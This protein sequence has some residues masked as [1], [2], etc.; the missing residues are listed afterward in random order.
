MP[1]DIRH[2]VVLMLENR[3]YDH[4]VGYLSQRLGGLDGLAAGMGNHAVPKDATSPFVAVSPA[5]NDIIGKDPDHDFEGAT[6]QLFGSTTAPVPPAATCDGF[7]ASHVKTTGGSLAKGA[8]VMQCVAEHRI[9]ALAHLAEH[10]A[11]C[12]HWYS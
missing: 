11:I 6:L 3:S 5:A 12:D 1:Q 2:L 4:L 8:E 7:L 9:P 10:F